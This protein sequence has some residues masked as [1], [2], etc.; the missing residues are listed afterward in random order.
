MYFLRRKAKIKMVIKYFI[1]PVNK[2]TK[3]EKDNTP[4]ATKTKI[5]KTCKNI[6]DLKKF[7]LW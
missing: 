7:I 4:V 1:L 6:L 2:E 3:K 5:S